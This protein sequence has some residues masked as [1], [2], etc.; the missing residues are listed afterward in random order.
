MKKGFKKDLRFFIKAWF[1]IISSIIGII[2]VYYNP[3][4][5]CINSLIVVVSPWV[6]LFF[7]WLFINWIL[8]V[9]RGGK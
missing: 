1:G 9:K 3:I 4:N 8:P 2:V 6:G 5:F 7:G